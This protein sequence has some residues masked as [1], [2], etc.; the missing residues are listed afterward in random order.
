MLACAGS[1]AFA[2]S[3]EEQVVTQLNAQ[4]FASVEMNRT[5]LGRLRF[6]AVSDRLRREIVVH[7]TTGAVLFDN[8]TRLNGSGV[9]LVS[10][11]DD[12][13]PEEDDE[14][15]EDFEDEEDDEEDEDD[16]EEDDEDDE[17][18]EDEGDDDDDD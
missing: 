4:G 7:P 10:L 13:P 14:D 12:R 11:S 8:V 6:V 16:E 3:I 1:P 9:P 5:L 17:D 2:Q 18:D 15:D